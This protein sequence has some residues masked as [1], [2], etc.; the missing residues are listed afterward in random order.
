[1]LLIIVMVTQFVLLRNDGDLIDLTLNLRLK[2]LLGTVSV[3]VSIAV[4]IVLMHR[5]NDPVV[6]L[7]WGWIAGRAIFEC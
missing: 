7:C 2:V 1:M 5:L 4:A 3:G 6:G